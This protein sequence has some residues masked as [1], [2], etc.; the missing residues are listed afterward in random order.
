MSKTEFSFMGVGEHNLLKKE[1]KTS[2]IISVYECRKLEFS[3]MSVGEH[4]LLK[5]ESKN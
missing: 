3:F 4:N 5:M 2:L 1:S